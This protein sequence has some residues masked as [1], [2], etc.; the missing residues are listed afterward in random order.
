[1]LLLVNQKCKSKASFKNETYKI[2]STFKVSNS[3][4]HILNF[5]LAYVQ[6]WMQK[7]LS[8]QESQK[9]TRIPKL[10]FRSTI[11]QIDR[12]SQ[13]FNLIPWRWWF[14]RMCRVQLFSSSNSTAGCSHIVTLLIVNSRSCGEKILALLNLLHLEW[15]PAKQQWQMRSM[16]ASLRFSSCRS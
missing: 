12:E 5:T 1:M 16:R 14:C 6:E 7:C 8:T 15:Q 11:N 4:I 10:I 9:H 2:S 13:W 3:N